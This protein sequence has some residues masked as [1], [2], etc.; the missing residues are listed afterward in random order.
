MH[1][2]VRRVGLVKN[3]PAQLTNQA[4]YAVVEFALT[5]PALVLC[6]FLVTALLGLASTQLVL[7]SNAALGARIVGRGDPLPDSY[8]SS[9]PKETKVIVT[10]NGDLVSVE[11]QSNQAFGKSPF[12]HEV[13]LKA[14]ST[15][16]LEQNFSEFN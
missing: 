5:I 3:W 2:K 6:G 7:E 9:L 1:K 13:T 10:P 11:L 14:S 8:L 15:A 4:G 16:R 12:V